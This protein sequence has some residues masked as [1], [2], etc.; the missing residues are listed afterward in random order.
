[1]DITGDFRKLARQETTKRQS[2]LPKGQKD[3]GRFDILPPRRPDFSHPEGNAFLAEAYIVA[4]HLQSL[5]VRIVDIRPA[6]LNLQSRSHARRLGALGTAAGGGGYGRQSSAKLSDP[7]RDDID[8]GIKQAIRQMLAKI[9]S[10]N[11]LAETTLE[12]M[13]NDAREELE[14]AKVL[15][16]RLL[17]ALDPRNADAKHDT[18]SSPASQPGLPMEMSRRDVL[19]AHQSSVIWWLNSLLQKTN[20]IHA[21]MQE[22]YL[23]QKLERQR[24][25]LSQQ[26]QQQQ[27]VASV[28]RT[29]SVSDDKH[30]ARN[31]DQN[32]ILSHLSPQELKALQTENQNIVLEFESAL[33]Q[34]T[35]QLYNEAVGALDAVDKGNDYL[36]SARKNQSSSRKWV[37]VN[38]IEPVTDE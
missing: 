11:E 35:E 9:Q 29:T 19:A 13:P 4:K 36:V 30:S 3:L 20:K 25:L 5:R 16:R 6:Y 26:Q 33:D 17:G 10:L 38:T 8:R 37:L 22:L 31:S 12:N 1:M 32:E 14:N 27:S 24:N 2:S 34:Q 15:F 21:E 23:R 28:A 7:E 18:A